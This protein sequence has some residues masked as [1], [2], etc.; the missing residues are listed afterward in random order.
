MSRA[1]SQPGGHGVGCRGEAGRLRGPVFLL[2]LGRH[3]HVIERRQ[4]PRPDDRSVLN[5]GDNRDTVENRAGRRGGVA[6]GGQ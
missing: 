4:P 5:S 3:I 6:I 1:V 2:D